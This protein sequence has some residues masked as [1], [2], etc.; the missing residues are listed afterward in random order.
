VNC[1]TRESDLGHMESIQPTKVRV[2][3]G[4]NPGCPLLLRI[5]PCGTRAAMEGE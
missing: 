5:S 2:P 4:R 1:E 3:Q